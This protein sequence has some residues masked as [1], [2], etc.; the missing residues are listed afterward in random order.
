MEDELAVRAIAGD[1]Q[2]I[3]LLI[4]QEEAILYRTAFAYLKNEQ[5]ALDVMQELFVKALKKIHTVKKPQFVRTWLMR[6]L[7][8]SCINML[9]K[10]KSVTLL[11]K[12]EMVVRMETTKYEI[13][14]MLSSLPLSDQQLVYMKYFQQLKNSEIAQLQKI[15][16]G[17]VKSKIHHIL[18]RL[19]I[20]AG[21]REDW[22]G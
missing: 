17:T 2:A 13:L 7:I 11:E 8:N 16:E 9:R 12:H 18:K 5:D 21:E 19:R 3:L 22:H 4:E 15:P 14:H 20:V 6:V 10:Q 1:Q